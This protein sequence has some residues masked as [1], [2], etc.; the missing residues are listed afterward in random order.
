MAQPAPSLAVHDDGA[1]RAVLRSGED[2]VLLAAEVFGDDHGDAV[3]PD[4]ED[5]GTRLLAGTA[6][7][8]GLAVDGDV[9]RCYLRA[10]RAAWGLR[11]RPCGTWSP[12]RLGRP[13]RM[14]GAA[15]SGPRRCSAQRA[16][17]L[18]ARRAAGQGERAQRAGEACGARPLRVRG[19]CGVTWTA[20]RPEAARERTA[21]V[22]QD[23]PGVSNAWRV[24][25]KRGGRP[26]SYGTYRLRSRTTGTTV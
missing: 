21:S 22:L 23:R 17:F 25:A 9:Q 24:N 7:Y 19:A 26:R 20:E 12:R 1:L 2:T 11:P 5:I 6:A 3:V 13:Q 8:A 18:P 16:C 14:R 10:W 15:R 4:L